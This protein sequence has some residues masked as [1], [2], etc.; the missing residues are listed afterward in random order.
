MSYVDEIYERV[1]SQNPGEPEFHQAVKEVLD[2]LSWL[3]TPTRRSTARP[4][5]WSVLLNRKGL[6]PSGYLGWTITARYR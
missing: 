4:V 1:V 6:F 3:L 5:S 2:S